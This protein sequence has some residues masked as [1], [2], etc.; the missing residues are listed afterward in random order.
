MASWTPFTAP[1]DRRGP[2]ELWGT[3]GDPT[4]LTAEAF[5][6][7]TQVQRGGERGGSSKAP[8]QPQLG[9]LSRGL[10]CR[11]LPA[12]ETDSQTGCREQK[13][14][15]SQRMETDSETGPWP[16]RREGSQGRCSQGLWGLPGV[17]AQRIS[18]RSLSKTAHWSPKPTVT[19]WDPGRAGGPSIPSQP[20]CGCLS[21]G[22]STSALCRPG[23]PGRTRL[24]RGSGTGQPSSCTWMG[25]ERP[26]PTLP[27]CG[28]A[29]IQL[30]STWM[31]LLMGSSLPPRG[32]PKG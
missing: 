16:G 17:F 31:L 18:Q 21:T 6:A 13:E 26:A 8:A 12:T 3:V 4:S 27:S 2:G 25:P 19:H 22:T 7:Q 10:P 1:A 30:V 9:A 24:T 11:L 23:V 28:G 20:Q 32:S 14:T 15:W 29:D 5:H